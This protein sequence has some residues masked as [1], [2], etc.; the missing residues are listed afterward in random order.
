MD[1]QQ[2]LNE[3]TSRV[4]PYIGIMPQSTFSNAVKA[5]RNGTYKAKE[6]EKF[7]ELFGYFKAVELWEKI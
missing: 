5:I 7:M 6:T 2:I 3:I 4:K 1:K